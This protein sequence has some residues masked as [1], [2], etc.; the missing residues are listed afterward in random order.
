MDIHAVR[1][2]RN[3]LA[4]LQTDHQAAMKQVEQALYAYHADIKNDP[5]KSQ[6]RGAAACQEKRF[7]VIAPRAGQGAPEKCF[8]P[9]LFFSHA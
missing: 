3:R 8:D 5:S 9:P 2:H 4:H 7:P 6:V 1:I